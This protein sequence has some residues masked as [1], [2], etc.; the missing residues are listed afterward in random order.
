MKSFLADSKWDSYIRDYLKELEFNHP[1]NAWIYFHE[2]NQIKQ[3]QK[4]KTEI[5]QRQQLL[6]EMAHFLNSCDMNTLI[7]QQLKN[8]ILEIFVDRFQITRLKKAEIIKLIQLILIG[9]NYQKEMVLKKFNE[10]LEESINME[11]ILRN[12]IRCLYYKN[13]MLKYEEIR[14]G[15]VDVNWKMLKEFF[16][17]VNYEQKEINEILN[18]IIDNAGN[19]NDFGKNLFNELII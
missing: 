19:I 10:D 1:Q 11:K 6:L 4:Q 8:K 18:E 13:I 14:R 16:S 17:G 5:N 7:E 15:I 12:I 3:I 2:K 9:L